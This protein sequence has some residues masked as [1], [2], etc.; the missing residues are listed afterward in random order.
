MEIK[1]K[2]LL[3][4]AKEAAGL[5]VMIDVFR[6]FTTAAYVM[7]NNADR[8]MPVGGVENSF[9]IKKENPDYILMGE[10]KGVK[11]D[12]FDYGNSPHAIRDVDFT[13]K[14]VIL[15]TS[16]GTQGIVN[17]ENADEIILGNF[18]CMKAIIG[19]IRKSDSRVVTLVPLGHFG[20]VKNDEDEMCA[21]YMKKSLEGREPDFNE[22]KECIRAS[23]SGSRFFDDTKPEF[24]QE[25]FE[26][27]MDLNRFDFVLK[28][29]KTD[30]GERIIKK[31]EVSELTS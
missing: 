10:R 16:A 6:A 9:R 20:M 2:S 28:V 21:S 1:V 8:I 26:L 19:Y 15:T 3:D 4:G 7:N 17:A 12:G 14:T 13:G 22:V 24:P 11:I 31:V 27:S 23:K 29:M 30:E 25:D 18:V 5:T